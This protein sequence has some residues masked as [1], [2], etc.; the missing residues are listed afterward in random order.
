MKSFHFIHSILL[1]LVTAFTHAL[2]SSPNTMKRIL[3]TGG[4]KGIGRAICER[5]LNEWDN[6]HVILTARNAERGKSAVDDIVQTLQCSPDRIT[7]LE[8][9]VASDESV[10]AASVAF[11]KM[12]SDVT[13]D[14]IINNAG[15]SRTEAYHLS[16]IIITSSSNLTDSF[17]DW[18]GIYHRRNSKHQLLWC[19]SRQR[20]VC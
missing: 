9:D 7:F 20:C 19:P 2:S 11:E 6:T 13:L 1:L 17:K 3:V 14:G 4:N 16:P 10:K 8:M 5:L 12:N 15:V 18:L